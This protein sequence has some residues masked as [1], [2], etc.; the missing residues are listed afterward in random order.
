[1]IKRVTTKFFSCSDHRKL[2]CSLLSYGDYAPRTFVALVALYNLFGRIRLGRIVRVGQCLP[3][4]RRLFTFNGGSSFFYTSP[5]ANKIQPVVPTAF[6]NLLPA[7]E[8]ASAGANH[9]TG[10]G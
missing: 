9:R 7:N 6:N 2:L 4:T 10:N 1:M 5:Y 3:K 8:R